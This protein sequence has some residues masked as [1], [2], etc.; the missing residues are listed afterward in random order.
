VLAA[1]GLD[2][3][4]LEA[5]R[6]ACGST[7]GSLG[8]MLP[9]PDA[10]FRDVEAASGR[11]VSRTAWADAHRSAAD[12]AAAIRKLNITC[13][14]TP[15]AHLINARSADEGAFLRREQAARRAGRRRRAMDYASGRSRNQGW[16][17]PAR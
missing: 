8:A 5:D 14:L 15:S 6:L 7:A 17:P 16:S 13:D 11:R 10:W 4:L 9:E 12:F 2:V 1:G 3:I